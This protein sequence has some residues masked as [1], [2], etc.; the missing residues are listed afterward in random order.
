M[1]VDDFRA[2][3]LE[4]EKDLRPLVPSAWSLILIIIGRIKWVIKFRANG[5]DADLSVWRCQLWSERNQIIRCKNMVHRITSSIFVCS[6]WR[7]DQRSISRMRTSTNCHL[8]DYY[9]GYRGRRR[10]H[11]QYL[12]LGDLECL[13]LQKEGRGAKVEERRKRIRRKRRRNGWRRKVEGTEGEGRKSSV[14]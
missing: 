11:F 14:P 9:V 7:F 3:Q 10:Y 1:S 13:S 8:Q 12:G 6:G 5:G 4:R 2:V